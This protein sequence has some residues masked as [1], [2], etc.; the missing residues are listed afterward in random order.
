MGN[1]KNP[2]EVRELTKTMTSVLFN[3]NFVLNFYLG[4]VYGQCKELYRGERA[5]QNNDVSTV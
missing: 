1:V 4:L 2:I 3:S 5:D